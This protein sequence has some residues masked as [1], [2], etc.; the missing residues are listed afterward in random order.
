MFWKSIYGLLG[1]EVSLKF[2]RCCFDPTTN[3][4]VPTTQRQLCRSG[5]RHGV[6]CGSCVA[7]ST[8]GKNPQ[9]SSPTHKRCD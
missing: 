3:F 7:T 4:P 5:T 6:F 2:E 9:I 8:R 1:P